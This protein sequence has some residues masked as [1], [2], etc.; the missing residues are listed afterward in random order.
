MIDKRSRKTGFPFKHLGDNIE[1][2]SGYV[3]IITMRLAG[4]G[5]PRGCHAGVR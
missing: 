3:L 1:T 4:A 2:T 5:V